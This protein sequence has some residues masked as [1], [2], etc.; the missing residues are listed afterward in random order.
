MERKGVAKAAGLC[1]KWKAALPRM[2]KADGNA[3]LDFPREIHGFRA[4]RFG[5]AARRVAPRGHQAIERR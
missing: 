2:E 1:R 4:Q 3:G 5:K